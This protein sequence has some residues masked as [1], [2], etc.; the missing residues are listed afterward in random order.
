MHVA[1]TQTHP[2]TTRRAPARSRPLAPRRPSLSGRDRS[3]LGVSPAAVS[4]W[5]KQLHDGPRGLAALRRY[6]KPG[7]P[8]RLRPSQW[9]QLLGIL[10][11]GKAVRLRDPAL[12]PAEGPRRDRAAIWGDVSCGLP[13]D[14]AEG[15]GLEHQVPAVRAAERDEELI[16]AWLDRDWPRIKKRLA[17]ETP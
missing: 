11:G 14:P 10:A 4:Q 7:R 15:P 3:A 1:T 9:Q 5:A 17:A 2:R 12:D 13:L 16:R 8:P 6:P